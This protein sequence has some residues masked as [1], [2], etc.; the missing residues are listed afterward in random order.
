[1]AKSIFLPQRVRPVHKRN[2]V[3]RAKSWM[4][5]DKGEMTWV[6]PW[7]QNILHDE[8]ERYILARSFDTDLTGFNTTHPSLWIGLDKRVLT[9]GD[10]EVDTLA[11]VI[12]AS[13]TGGG[14]ET[15]LGTPPYARQ[16][17]STTAGFT[18]EVSGAFYQVRS[19]NVAFTAPT[20]GAAIG[21]VRNRF[22]CSAAS[23]APAGAILIASLPFTN[24]IERTINAGDTLNTNFII[25]LTEP[26]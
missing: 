26:A 14:G 7:V 23:G 17:V 5:N 22:L 15:E 20:G 12:G 13:A 10:H 25:G 16:E 2:S 21:T 1:M 8:G 19:I 9:S 18:M 11:T 3:F 6:D 24:N 4:T